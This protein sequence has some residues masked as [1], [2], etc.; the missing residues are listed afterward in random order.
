[1]ANLTDP[2]FGKNTTNL[3]TTGLHGSRQKLIISMLNSILSITAFLGN[4]LIIF[5]LRKVSSFHPPSVWLFILAI[6]GLCVGLFT[7]PLHVAFL[8]SPETSEQ[9]FYLAIL[10]NIISVIIGGASL[11]TVTAIVTDFSPFSWD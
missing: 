2:E 8:T 11:F 9:C 4:I 5:V 1:M 10:F 7:Q 3:C 6:T